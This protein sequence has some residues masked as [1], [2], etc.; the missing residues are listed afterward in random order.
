MSDK[1]DCPE[2][3]RLA[4]KALPSMETLMDGKIEY[5]VESPT[6]YVDGVYQPRPLVFCVFKKADRPLAWKNT[7]QKVQSTLP[8]IGNDPIATGGLQTP[9]SQDGEQN[10]TR[11][12]R[13]VIRLQS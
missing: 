9:Q 2:K 11:L 12:I 13:V 10:P 3:F 1:G 8:L 5:Y 4:Q 7:D 6:W